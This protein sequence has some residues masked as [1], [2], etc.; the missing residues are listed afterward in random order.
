MEGDE[1]TVM[2]DDKFFRHGDC[3][4]RR[5]ETIGLKEI[6][7]GIPVQK[8][9]E[10]L[11]GEN[12]HSHMFKQGLIYELEKPQDYKVVADGRTVQVLKFVDLKQ[13]TELIHHEH[14]TRVIPAGKYALVRER[15]LDVLEQKTRS[16]YE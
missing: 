16:V 9:L 3:V 4:G 15:E 14:D 6:P 7:E 2:N 1:V 13:E 12:G 11:H 5:I 10:L 8:S